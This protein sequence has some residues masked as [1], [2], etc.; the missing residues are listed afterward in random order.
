MSTQANRLQN[1]VNKLEELEPGVWPTHIYN[2]AIMLRKSMWLTREAQ[3]NMLLSGKM[4]DNGVFKIE[5]G[6]KANIERLQSMSKLLV[7]IDKE[8]RKFYLNTWMTTNECGTTAC[9]CGWLTYTPEWVA[10]G[11][12][13]QELALRCSN[14]RITYPKYGW[15]A[16]CHWFGI[17]EPM[18]YN[19]FNGTIMHS[20]LH[21][22]G[23]ADVSGSVESQPAHNEKSTALDVKMHLDDVLKDGHVFVQTD[24]TILIN[25]IN[26]TLRELNFKFEEANM[27]DRFEYI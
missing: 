27:A 13:A 16:V 22:L 4:P 2:Q 25:K 26:D 23:L 5:L 9:A 21:E 6:A 3:M 15:N 11:G 20:Y 1:L 24:L 17:S 18:A 10:G 7:Q 12:Y 19:L 14:G 8:E